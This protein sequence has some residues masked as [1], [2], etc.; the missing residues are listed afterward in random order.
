MPVT[1]FPTMTT[2]GASPL[3][4]MIGG[5]GS[6][7]L[8]G[9]NLP[10]LTMPNIDAGSLSTD[11]RQVYS[12]LAQ[13]QQ[14]LTSIIGPLLQQVFG[15][16]GNLMQ[17][18]FQQMGGQNAAQAQSDAMARGLSGSSIEAANMMGA[19]TGANQSFAQYLAGQLSN[20]V[21]QYAGAAQFD[22][23]GANQQYSNLAQ[24]VGQQVS[25]QLQQRQFEQ[26][27]STLLRQANIAANAQEMSGLFQGLGSLG[28]GIMAAA[29]F[30]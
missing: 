28:G 13:P 18:L 5:N 3:G 2:Q 27:M 16:Q 8:P 1:P 20:L 15:T 14:S 17:G 9:L 4:G 12:L 21:P 11:P 30:L 26:Q 29:P 22:I 6:S 7:G 23:T 25:S 19:R 10:G 24:A